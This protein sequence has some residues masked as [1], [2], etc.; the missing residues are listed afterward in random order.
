METL[1]TSPEFFMGVE[2]DSNLLHL[3]E[4]N[5]SM[6]FPSEQGEVYNVYSPLGEQ[7]EPLSG[8]A[9]YRSLCF[10]QDFSKQKVSTSE[11]MHSC[12]VN[13]AWEERFIIWQK[14]SKAER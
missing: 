12:I 4:Y 13:Y 2:V 11:R 9:K 5:D 14:C 3:P 8:Q 10:E 1:M 7:I 6:M